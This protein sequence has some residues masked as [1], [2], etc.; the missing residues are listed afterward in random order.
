MAGVGG[1][2]GL[3]RSWSWAWKF[4]GILGLTMLCIGNSMDSVLVAIW[5]ERNKRHGDYRPRDEQYNLC[6][7]LLAKTQLFASFVSDA[8][9]TTFGLVANSAFT[10]IGHMLQAVMLP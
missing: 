2:I 8:T 7:H 10:T 1:R 5:C 3:C 6:K 9:S 4:T